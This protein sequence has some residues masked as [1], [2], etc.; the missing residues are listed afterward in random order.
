MGRVS[1]EI[2]SDWRL[3]EGVIELAEKL[4]SRRSRDLNG[5]IEVSFD[6]FSSYFLYHYIRNVMIHEMKEKNQVFMNGRP[7]GG[8]ETHLRRRVGRT[9]SAA[10]GGKKNKEK[11]KRK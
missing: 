4:R 1:G 11:K 3:F 2:G 8:E 5:Q 6:V 9:R 10:S 7:T